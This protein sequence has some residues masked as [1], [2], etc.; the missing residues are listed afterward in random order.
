MTD[1]IRN[2]LQRAIDTHGAQIQIFK[3]VE[4]MGELTQALA[5]LAGNAPALLHVTHRRYCALRKRRQRRAG[6]RRIRPGWSPLPKA[7]G[8]LL[9]VQAPA[10]PGWHPEDSPG[11][12]APDG[13]VKGATAINADAPN[14]DY[15][16]MVDH[17]AEEVADVRIMLDQLCMIFDVE[18]RAVRWRWHKLQRLKDR[19][20]QMEDKP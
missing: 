13:S 14:P 3:T 10:A 2:L 16:Q 17:V 8:R 5:K 4:E 1:T 11:L 15:N 20:D 9:S 12:V 18:D 7:V 19:L 6:I